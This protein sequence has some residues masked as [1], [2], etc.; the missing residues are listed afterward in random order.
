MNYIRDGA[1]IRELRV[2]QV[3]VAT[4]A[5]VNTCFLSQYLRGLVNLTE[6]Q[7]EEIAFV[8]QAMR[9]IDDE[10]VTPIDWKRGMALRP[11]IEA[12]VQEYRR[13]RSAELHRNFLMEAT[14]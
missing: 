8:V 7:R 13:A 6:R 1:T 2:P 10:S 5:N 12:K 9:E 14:V 11:Q 4:I 3:I